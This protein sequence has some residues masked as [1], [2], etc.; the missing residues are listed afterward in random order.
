MY[1][2]TPGSTIPLGVTKTDSGYN[3]SL[4][5][6]HAAK[7]LLTLFF[8]KHDQPFLQ[9]PMHKTDKIWHLSLENLPTE[10]E[11]CY[12][13]EGNNAAQKG[14]A[15]NPNTYLLDPYAKNLNSSSTWGK[16]DSVYKTKKLRG[17]VG[18]EI[19]FDWEDDAPP[20]HLMT[21]LIIYEM[22]VR[23][24]TAS[25]SSK[26]LHPGTF[27]AI[28]DKIPFLKELG[29]N[30]IELLPV[31]EF[32]EQEYDKKNPQTKEQL[33]NFWG[34]SSV[35]FFSPMHRFG[36]S[37]IYGAAAIDFKKMVKELHKNG[38]E[39][40]LDVVYN[41]TAEGSMQGPTF[42]FRGIDNTAYYMV[43]HEG[44]YRDYTGCG[45]TLNA[46]HPV[47]QRLILDSLR[48][49][50]E[51]MH[52]DGFR[53]D[54]ASVLTRGTNGAPLEHPPLI[55][56][57]D[58]DPILSKIKRIAEPWDA[59]GLYQVGSFPGKWAEWNGK[60]RDTV[61]RFIKGTDGQVGA[62][63]MVLSGSEDIFRSS[64]NPSNSINFIT[65]HDGYTLYDLVSYQGKYNLANGEN[66]RDGN[67]QNESWNC[68]AEGPTDNPKI[69][70]LRERQM[71]NFH[72]ALLLSFGVPMMQMGDEY[73]HTRRGNN[74]SWCQDNDL[75]WY[76][77]DQLEQHKDF[78]RFC[79]LVNQWRKNQPLFHK[80]F[81]LKKEEIDWHGLHPYAPDWSPKCRTIAYTLKDTIKGESL[82]IAFNANFTPA[83][84]HLPPSSPEK[85][86][87]RLIDT[88]LP[89]PHDFEPDPRETSPL[90]SYTIPA[91]SAFVSQALAPSS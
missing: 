9:M 87:F 73:G 53:F 61:R 2:A 11:Y 62:F 13:I 67:N 52:V 37:S 30:A 10:F 47:C 14:L 80:N 24:F 76:Q 88:S 45:N 68:G 50:V 72:L 69:K 59:A 51:E 91:H 90:T 49:W 15:F 82:Y 42:S 17:R 46:N 48:Y 84:F 44:K 1:H 60:Y 34:Y 8:P 31:Y 32:N 43:D 79:S 81:F 36:S 86:W 29:V 16:E 74:N 4:Y 20:R 83:T 55:E 85:K 21:E 75:N 56:A 6:Q 33:Y 58:R 64:K 7:V 57:I 54:L 18:P 41:H 12:R 22:H 23:S 28:I 38:I 27:L 89:S 3:F 63:A 19:A 77:W 66:N 26:C 65:A 40:L 78:F 5:S 35:S 39:V 70:A 25:P 71:R